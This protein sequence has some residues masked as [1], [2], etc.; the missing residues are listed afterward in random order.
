MKFTPLREMMSKGTSP[1]SNVV[2]DRRRRRALALAGAVEPLESRTLLAATGLV[3]AYA[4]DEGAGNSVADASGTGNTGAPANTTWSTAGK[5]GGALSFNGA[6]SWVTVADNATLRLTNGMTL[7]AWVN[8]TSRTGFQAVLIKER[9]AGL[10]YALY[11]ND[12]SSRPPAVYVNTGGSDKSAVGTAN[13]A[14]NAWS[15][16]A[17]TYNGSS[18]RFYVNGALVRTTAVTGN[19]A[20]STGGA[21]RIGGNSVWGEYFAGLIDD[22]RVYNRALT[23]AEIQT[24]MATPVTPPAPDTTAPTVAVT[25]PTAGATVAGPV[26]LTA[27]ATDNVGVFGVQFYVD[28]NA[29][30]SE[31]VTAPYS[32]TW[33]SAAIG[34]GNHTITARARDAANNPATSAGVTV[35]VNNVIDVTAPTVSVTAPADGASVSGTVAITA[36]AGDDVG[37]VGVQFRVDGVNVGAEDTTAPYA[38]NWNTATYSNANHILTAVARDAAGRS[39]T[40]ALVNVTVA[41]ADTTPPTVSLTAPAN[42]ATLTNTVTFSANASDNIGVFGVQFLLDGNPLGDEDLTA[43]YSISVDTRTIPNGTH[44][45]SA[46][47]RDAAGNPTTSATRNVNVST[48]ITDPTVV[49]PRSGDSNWPRIASNMVL[50]KTGKILM[51]DGGPDCI[52]AV[53]ARVWDPATNVFTQVPSENRQDFRDIFCSAQTVLPDGRVLVVGGHECVDTTY[54]GSAIANIFD[55]V[56]QAWTKLPDM[57]YR[58]WYP[59]VTTLPDGRALVTAGSDFTNTSYIPIPE[60][61]DPATNTFTKL[62]SAS[63]VIPNYPFMFVLPD[64]RVLAAGSDESKMGTFALDVAT[65]TWTTID[66]RVLDGGSAVMYLP[67]KVMK[68]GSSYYSDTL[69]H[70]GEAAAATTYVLD[71]TA[72]TPAWQQT[73]SMQ[74]GRAHHNLTLLADG[75]VLATGGSNN[76]GGWDPNAAVYPAEIWSPVTKT[77]TTVAREATPRMYH[78]TSLLLPDGRVVSAGGGHNYVNNADYPNSEIYSPPY[79]FKG[80]RPVI[81]GAPAV[82]DYNA[83]FFLATPDAARIA[84]VQLIRNGAVTHEV[85]MDQRFVPLSF[86]Q[87]AGGLTVHGPA[88]LNTAPPGTYMLFIVDTN[89]V[90]CVAPFVHLPAA[91][92]DHTPPTAPT[93]LTASAPAI[94]TA[95]LLW[96]AATD[97]LG[98][99]KY[100]VYRSNVADFTPTVGNRIAQVTGLSFTDSG[101]AAGTWY[102]V[103]IAQDANGNVGPASGYASATVTADTTAP[104]VSVTNPL[105]GATVSGTINLTANAADDVG[106]AAVQFFVDGVAFGAPDTTA[107]F[108][109]AWNSVG[110]SNGTHS[111]TARASDAAGNALTSAPVSFTVSNSTVVAGLVG[112]WGFEDG[113]GT[114]ATDSSGKNLNGTIANAAWT[115][116]GRFGSALSFNGT[117]SW[118]TVADNTALDFTNGMTLEDWVKPNTLTGYTTVLM[119]ERGTTGLNYS[120]YASDN[121]GQ[122]PAAYVYRGSDI[123]A[124]GATT[125][126]IGAWSHLA[127]TYDG[128]NLR[129]YVN[130]A[131]VRTRAVSGNL[132]NTANPLRIGGNAVWGEYFSGLIDEVR[133]YNRALSQTELQTDMNTAVN[134]APAAMMA[135]APMLAA[136]TVQTPSPPVTRK[137]APKPT[138]VYRP[139]FAS[140]PIGPQAFATATNITLDDDKTRGNVLA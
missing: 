86:T 57:A 138:A 135:A 91:S 27:S 45:I 6:N 100:N 68:S 18:L 97:N 121:T 94:G 125:L 136:M 38:Y 56:T 13:L 66:S 119:K 59:T 76:L 9:T 118:V 80:P 16:L 61:Y 23:Q 104:T 123:S 127:A 110:A 96:N 85:D 4:F 42:N 28:G 11:S 49:G 102:Y 126:T 131:L 111:V 15:H 77:W 65:Q 132:A 67:G 120:L 79:L 26:T 54:T 78:S 95:S 124:L 93:G 117:N 60:L 20:A 74:F 84:S 115:T 12:D 109:I 128:A 32:I 87:A 43:P 89:G 22:A 140:R 71:M 48:V 5:Y 47:A 88:D 105:A 62:T 52:G 24:D 55:P 14:L 34:N 133:V 81:T 36:N 46:R 3:A 53:S 134:P 98:V 113:V 58:R 72:P 7:E 51:W 1:K 63:K 82:V 99:A 122:P 112:A 30:G 41:N 108:S 33:D 64:G 73:G 2:T 29:V 70:D 8:P 31:D 25:A 44:T 103:V 130:G 101:L 40:S 114:T 69:V 92:E 39:T 17:A 10:S 106:V 107:P 21:L 35:N 129:L 137:A 90:P 83:D 139:P 116:A 37:V 75:S 50:L 19:L